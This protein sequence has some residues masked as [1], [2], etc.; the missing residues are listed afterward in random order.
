MPL[1]R[2]CSSQSEESGVTLRVLRSLLIPHLVN[3]L[4][5]YSALLRRNDRLNSQSF[6]GDLALYG[7]PL[8]SKL[9][10]FSFVSFQCVDFAPDDQGVLHPLFHAHPGTLSGALVLGHM[11][12]TA[13]RI[14][15]DSG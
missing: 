1:R 7:R 2:A 9:V 3:I 6:T 15:H 5:T 4:A 14:T 10:Q 12:S 8:T 11:V 13:H